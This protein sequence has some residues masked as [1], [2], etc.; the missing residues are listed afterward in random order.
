MPPLPHVAAPGVFRNGT[1]NQSQGQ[2]YSAKLVRR[3][4]SALG[5]VNGWRKR[6]STATQ[7]TGSPVRPWQS[8]LIVCR[9]AS[10]NG[11]LRRN[12]AMHHDLK[13]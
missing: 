7:L 13:R 11:D 10:V 6:L 12:E 4:G 1:E 8:D 9:E 3:Y 2:Y 5:P